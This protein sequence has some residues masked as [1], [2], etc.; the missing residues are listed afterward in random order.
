MVRIF[1]RNDDV[2]D[3]TK[4]FEMMNRI[5]IRKNVPLHHSVIPKNISEPSAKKLTEIKAKN[6]EIIEYGQHGYSHENY[7]NENIKFEF[8]GRGYNRQ[9]R[10]IKIGKRII[11]EYL[12]PDACSIFTPPFH[13]YDKNTLNAVNELGF[14]VFS[15]D[16]RTRLDMNM[17]DF[18]FVPVSISFNLPT[19][20]KGKFT[21]NL[22]YIIKNFM[23]RKDKQP[24]IG[25][26]I[27][28]EMLDV[29]GFR[30][31]LFYLDYLKKENTDFCL[32]SEAI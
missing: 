9:K 1:F 13:K 2:G 24:F 3:I 30:N 15:A 28:H 17:Y 27:H 11:E 7:G 20:E 22:N 23:E 4:K 26:F 12:G 16:Y 25:I 31:L 19:S 32:L 18:S 5:F 29:Q 21:T 6:P 8:L 14:R 10:D